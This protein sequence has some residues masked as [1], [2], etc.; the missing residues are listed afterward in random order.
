MVLNWEKNRA[1]AD[2]ALSDVYKIECALIYECKS[3]H[4]LTDERI[5][6]FKVEAKNRLDNEVEKINKKEI[7]SQKIAHMCKN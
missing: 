3:T 7:S 6:E 4:S 2:I 1:P 5:E